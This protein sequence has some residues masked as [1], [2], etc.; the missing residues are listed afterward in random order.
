MFNL[1]KEKGLNINWLGHLEKEELY[2]HLSKA[3]YLFQTSLY[4]VY[5]TVVLE[6]F[7]F[8][9]PV[10][11]TNYFGVDELIKDFEN[12]IV[13][14]GNKFDEKNLI[15]MFRDK[16]KYSFMSNLCKSQFINSHQNHNNTAKFYKKIYK[17]LLLSF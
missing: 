14:K 2:Q 10:I 6:A 17:K 4:E 13:L 16:N 8:G 1:S 12:G 5:P 15:S 11:T 3:T 7:Q 9:T